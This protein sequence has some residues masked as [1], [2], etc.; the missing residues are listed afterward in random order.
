MAGMRTAPPQS[1]QVVP[2][3]GLRSGSLVQVWANRFYLNHISEIVQPE[4]R[5]VGTSQRYSQLTITLCLTELPPPCPTSKLVLPE[6]YIR[7]CS[8]RGYSC[9][10][11]PRVI[12]NKQS[13]C[14]GLRIDPSFQVG[15][16][17]VV[18]ESHITNFP[19]IGQP[20]VIFSNQSVTLCWTELRLTCPG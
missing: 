18:P 5:V 14:V 19:D 7:S 13:P 9:F 2:C 20:R 4:V 15:G 1:G 8:D 3:V 12:V 16:K 10:R 6:S 17:Q 11:Q